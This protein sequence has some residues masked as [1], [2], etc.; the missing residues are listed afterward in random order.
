MADENALTATDTQALRAALIGLIEERGLVAITLDDISA[1][2]GV[3]ATVVKAQFKNK[4]KLLLAF[5][6]EVLSALRGFKAAIKQVK[7]ADA[8]RLV[9]FKK[10]LP[11]IIDLFEYLRGESAFLHAVLGSNG[12][13]KFNARLRKLMTDDI[14]APIL[15]V[16]YSKDQGSAFL[17]YYTAY[18]GSAVVGVIEAWIAAGAPESSEEMAALL[19]RLLF[20]K[21]GDSI[22]K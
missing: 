9:A 21:P 13:A 16:V 8:M 14:A 15:R 17:D 2:A 4:N 19:M 20:F 12:H 1:R 3:D 5:E 7:P 11:V 10:P 6:N 22:K 18:V